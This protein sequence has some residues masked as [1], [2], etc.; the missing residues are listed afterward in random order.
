MALPN[1]NHSVCAECGGLCCKNSGCA[2]IPSD[3]SD[4]FRYNK[5]MKKLK[6]GKYSFKLAAQYNFYLAEYQ[7][8]LR[9]CIRNAE[10]DVIDL[11]S[12]PNRCSIWSPEKGCPFSDEERPYQGLHLIPAP[13]GF[14]C[15]DDFDDDFMFENWALV[16]SEL[17]MAFSEYSSGKSV[18]QVLYEQYTK[19]VESFR[20]QI[21]TKI[22]ESFAKKCL[23]V[24]EELLLQH[25]FL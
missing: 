20:N 6:T 4:P 25:G 18:I 17:E 2:L 9:L 5:L 22:R 11:F 23:F 19:N 24:T 13:Y 1:I 12:P 14:G 7:Y 10:R 21:G 3:I 16:Q 15:H 8:Q